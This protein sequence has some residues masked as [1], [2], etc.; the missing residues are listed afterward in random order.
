ML[1]HFVDQV[2]ERS[3]LRSFKRDGFEECIEDF[4]MSKTMLVPTFQLTL[5]RKVQFILFVRGE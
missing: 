4:K 5:G 3:D 2:L 1:A